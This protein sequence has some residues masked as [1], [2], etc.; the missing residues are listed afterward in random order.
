[1]A[2]SIALLV[3]SSS[4]EHLLA[5]GLFVTGCSPGGGASNYWT[6]LLG[7]NVNLSITMTF[8]ST[9]GALGWLDFNFS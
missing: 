7:G 5:L 4:G 3:L 2:Y 8:L 1:L 6:I 9:I